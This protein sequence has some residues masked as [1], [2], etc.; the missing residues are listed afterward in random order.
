MCGFFIANQIGMCDVQWALLSF[1]GLRTAD[2]APARSLSN[3]VSQGN[4]FQ[5][6]KGDISQAIAIAVERTRAAAILSRDGETVGR[7]S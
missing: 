4:V 5:T 6:S 7:R 1:D 3:M 2:A